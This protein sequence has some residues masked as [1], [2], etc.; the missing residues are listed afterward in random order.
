MPQRRT[1]DPTR[2]R[3]RSGPAPPA[4]M[5]VQLPAFAPAAPLP[6]NYAPAV[7]LARPAAPLKA[8]TVCVVRTPPARAPRPAPR[9]T[10]A[11]AR[12]RKAP[13]VHVPSDSIESTPGQTA[14]VAGFGALTLAVAA[15]ALAA[16]GGDASQLAACAAAA[17]GGWVFA[18]FGTAVYHWSVD[19]YGSKDTPL[20]GFQIAAFQGHHSSPWTITNREFANNLYRLT[21][22]TSPQM[23]ALCF[24]P[25]PP[26]ALAGASSALM[27]IVLSQELHRQAH[28]LRPNAYARVLQALGIALS[29][30]EHGR[31]HSSPF[32]GHYGIVSGLANPLLDGTL[33]FRRLEAAVYRFN[34]AE[35]VSWALDPSL[36]EASLKL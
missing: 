13:E 22:P 28:M 36:K 4:A 20:F 16:T 23:F 21:M 8:V 17:V 12:P 27:W 9:A 15:R 11:P 26:V 7:P 30:K 29:R 34:G 19:N 25:L 18:D 24:L 35:P 14:A 33:F 10:R 6:R 31:H 2:C 32:E 1:P 3:R 5:A